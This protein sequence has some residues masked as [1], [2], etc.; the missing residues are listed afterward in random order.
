MWAD[1]LIQEEV[2]YEIV[3]F[4]SASELEERISEADDCFKLLILDIQMDGMNDMKPAHLLREK[5]FYNK[6]WGG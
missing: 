5:G 2:P 4:S 6:C 1:I 3:D